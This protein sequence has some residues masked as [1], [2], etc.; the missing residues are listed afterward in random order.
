MWEVT[1]ARL[2]AA[3]VSF[4]ALFTLRS[5]L[6]APGLKHS[7]SLA[8]LIAQAVDDLLGAE[9]DLPAPEIRTREPVE[10]LGGPADNSRFL[11]AHVYAGEDLGAR[12]SDRG[13]RLRPGDARGFDPADGV[14][15]CP[16]ALA[17]NI[18]VGLP[19]SGDM[20]QPHPEPGDDLDGGPSVH[21]QVP[22]QH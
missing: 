17:W 12:A 14:G 8:A 11:G 13:G 6:V 10:F 1:Q 15:L 5:L 22:D 19:D 18:W 3:A 2:R 16:G 4:P 9:E 21:C 20:A 7:V